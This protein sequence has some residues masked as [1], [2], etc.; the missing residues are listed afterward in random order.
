MTRL[1][2]GARLRT[3][4]LGTATF[5]SGVTHE[6][7]PGWARDERTELFMRATTVFAGEG[8]FYEN[9]Q[10]SDQR[11]I[12]LVRKLAVTD[13]EWV[14]QFLPWLR[15]EGNIRTSAV[16][17]AAEAAQARA[18]AGLHA[19]A[20]LTTRQVV[21]AVIQRGDEPTEMVQYCLKT[22]GKIPVA[23]KRGIADAM[24]RLWRERAV[25]RYDK[26][27]RPLRFADAIELVHPDPSSVKAPQ[28]LVLTHDRYKDWDT[29]EAAADY[30]QGHR[31][32]ITA[33]FKYLLDERHHNA[34][35]TS[36][37]AQETGLQQELPGITFRRQLSLLDPKLR[38]TIAGIALDHPQH[39]A[40]RQIRLAAAGQWEWVMS[41]LGE[42]AKAPGGQVLDWSPL[43][44]RQRWELVIPWMGY[45]ALLRNLRNFEESGL[46][47]KWVEYVCE[48]IGNPLEV[49]NS[50]QFPF[51]FLSAFLNTRNVQWHP[52]LQDALNASLFRAPVLDGYTY[53]LVDLSG[54]M[55]NPLSDPQDRD[56]D[57]YRNG[58][59][60][61][62]P[63]RA[64]AALLFAVALAMKNAGKADLFCFANRNFKAEGIERGASVLPL[65]KTLQGQEHYIGKGTKLGQNMRETFDPSRYTRALVLTDEQTAAHGYGVNDFTAC[66]PDR[67][68]VYVWNLSGYG[69][70]VTQYRTNRVGLAGLTDASFGIIDRYEHNRDGVWPWELEKSV[71]MLD[72]LDE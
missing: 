59:P 36:D 4:P 16:M 39:E 65:I 8:Q 32:H 42:G 31:Q 72:D 54:S 48:K 30:E 9:A 22:W 51:R 61:V 11:A 40:N 49:M 3:A 52:A 28:D 21:S 33:L 35:I 67:T 19:G 24:I 37:I 69:K 6:G 25:L 71:P 66:V 64:Q 45:V 38:H 1:N 7:A 70:G 2:T 10:T 12:Q 20:P 34:D 46:H 18:Q 58:P 47:R 62:R 56:R 41:W 60:P 43:T 29:A 17:L 15:S 23:M 63:T 57:P 68:P 55:D 5:T 44:E 26:T 53:I 27:D 13:W 50:R 14:A